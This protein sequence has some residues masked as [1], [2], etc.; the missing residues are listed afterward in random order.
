VHYRQEKVENHFR[1]VVVQNKKQTEKV[2]YFLTN[3]F[4]LTAKEVADY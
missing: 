4:E 3:D 1:L 2:F